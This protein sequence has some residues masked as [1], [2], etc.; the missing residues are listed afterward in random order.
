[1][2]LLIDV[3]QRKTILGIKRLDLEI[4]IFDTFNEIPYFIKQYTND[5]ERIAITTGP[6]SF[7]GIRNGVAFVKAFEL[8]GI[9][10]FGFNTIEAIFRN[11]E[12]MDIVVIPSRRGKAFVGLR[13]G[14]I[15]EWNISLLEDYIKEHSNKR[16]L[17]TGEIA[18]IT[19]TNKNISV[20]D[21]YAVRGMGKWMEEDI[22]TSD[23]PLQPL[24]LHS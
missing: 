7:T 6:G 14:R 1:M 15:E 22:K 18:G 4:K 11:D 2:D 24:Y 20:S 8:K 21:E 3:S 5:I 10:V 23:F 16:V 12:K 19:D 17:F 9:E 13:E